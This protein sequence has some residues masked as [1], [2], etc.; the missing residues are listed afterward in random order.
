MV[1]T[2]LLIMRL[3]QSANVL[4]VILTLYYQAH[5]LNYTQILSFEIILSLAMAGA[6]V[7]LGVWAD[8][9]GRVRAL[10]W[11][12]VVFFFGAI[13]FLFARV[14][15][16]F[17]ISDLLYGLGLA[18]QSGAD[19]ALLAPGGTNWFARY[20]AVGAAAGLFSS[21]LAGWVL[22]VSGMHLLVL[23]NAATALFAGLSVFT[24]SNDAPASPSRT[25]PS[26]P[27]ARDGWRLVRTA[28]WIIAWTVAA[29]VGFRL[30]GINLMF[31]DLP[32]WVA[33]G[34]HGV[35]LGVGVAIL[36]AAGW[37][38]MLAPTIQAR[39]GSHTLLTVSQ[40]LTGGLVLTL[41]L[42]HSPWALAGCMAGALA[43]Q[44]LQTPVVETVIVQAVPDSI[45]VT[46]L[47]ILDL[48]SLLVTILCE[49]G[50]GLLADKS[51]S[52][53]LWA[54]G[55]VLLLMIPLWW[56]SRRNLAPSSRTR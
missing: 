2:R 50:V 9:Y 42:I 56:I 11:G 19:I 26:W 36:Y 49:L 33:A 17:L 37:A 12:N 43:L 39:L 38:S 5:G 35:W 51:L 18:W 15:W 55:A 28:P 46:V 21:L 23:L 24:M 47:S 10:K 8:R 31:L 34:W 54:S 3:F 6:T 53:A 22:Q 13:V 20:R 25:S 7:P 40:V 30:V 45:R 41:P 4:G 14:Y 1:L 27:V 29:A 52:W 32:L 16:Q 48:P 44:S